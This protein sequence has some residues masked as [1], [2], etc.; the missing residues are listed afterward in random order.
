[1]A[2]TRVAIVGAGTLG[3]STALHLTKSGQFDVTVVEAEHIAEGSSSRSIGIIE[4]Q[5][6]NE[7]DIAVRAFGL[8]FAKTLAAA[9]G[10]HIN[11]NGYLRLGDSDHAID[12]YTRSVELQKTYG[13]HDARVLDKADISRLIPELEM[14]D[15]VGGLYGPSDGYV[16]GHLFATS[17][18]TVARRGG[19]TILQKAKLLGVTSGAGDEIVLDTTRGS[20]TADVVVNAAGGWAAQVGDLLGAPVTLNPQRHQAITVT[21]SRPLGYTMPSVMDYVPGSGRAGL[22]FRHEN[23][24]S[25]FAGL[26][27]E[28]TIQDASDPDTVSYTVDESFVEQIAEALAHRLPGLDE[29]GLGRGWAGMYPMSFDQQ[30]VVGPHPTDSRIVCALGAGGN[31]IQLA[32]AI[33]KTVAEYLEGV[34]PSLAGPGSKWDSSRLST[35][36]PA[37]AGSNLQGAQQ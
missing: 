13:V 33:G 37:V 7:F 31:G 27:T 15:R 36:D 18:S 30:P 28:E 8:Q 20:I 32:P 14:G 11:V 9:E 16:D 10:L 12:Q 6:M 26:H 22:Y 19:A 29:A 23:D 2:K 5:Y 3:L 4:T 21:L 24:L 35:S 1:M 34:T 25:L 17:M